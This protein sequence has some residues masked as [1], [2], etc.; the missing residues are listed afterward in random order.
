MKNRTRKNKK[1]LLIIGVSLLV[2]LV[3]VCVSFFLFKSNILKYKKEIT[4]EVGDNVPTI[5]DYLYKDDQIDQEIVWEQLPSLDGKIFEVGEYH[6]K[7]VYNDEEIVITLV[8]K[9]TTP[10][11]ITSPDDIE[12]LAYE[13]DP[14]FLE[15]VTVTDNSMEDITA[16]VYGE[17][18]TE[19]VGEYILYYLAKDSSGNEAREELKLVVKDNPNVK[20]S[21][22][23]KNYTIKNYYGITYI[24]NN[25]IVNKT[26]SL[27]NN[28]VPT[29]LTTINGYI[30]VVD[31]VKEAFDNLKAA[32]AGLGL[33]IYA[34]SGYRSYADQNYIY[35]NYVKI[36]GQEIADTYSARAGY[37][38]HQ[39][40]LAIDLNTID[41]S[42]E[43][44]AESNWLQ[45][46]CYEFGFIIRY[47]KG[48]ENITGYMYEPWH[49]RYVGKE[50]AEKLYNNGSWLTIE[51]YYGI[52]SKY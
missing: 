15:N 35:N 22:S 4:I 34:S 43:N 49:I 41:S 51:E 31:Y 7:F 10:P 5:A 17:Y 16:S 48:K 28:Y 37:S 26:Y 24:E 38:E 3:I 50:L 11:V 47:P 29:N 2:I 21:T 36:D 44:T 40:G 45:E 8:V 9:D 12:M 52:E 23:S 18:D 14:N 19:K 32:S 27:P 39:T 1:K 20:V 25:V 46:H 30:R 33:N 13:Q 6:G 42:F